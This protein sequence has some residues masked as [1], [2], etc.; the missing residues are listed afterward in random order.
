MMVVQALGAALFALMGLLAVMLTPIG[1][2]GAWMLIGVAGTVDATAMVFERGS[3]PFGA[4]SLAVAVGAAVA[5]ELLEFVAGAMG[6]RA[7]GA[8]RS[9]MV[10]SLV[11]GFVGVVVGTLAIPLPLVGSIVGA[12]LGVVLGA[13]VGEMAF[14]G[15]AL[16]DTVRP[17]AGAAIGRVVGSLAKLP[18]AF[19]AW[20]ALSYD[21]FT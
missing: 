16:G 1:V 8:S 10:G 4:E 12:L 2:P 9:G 13:V 14:H 20:A 21:A 11:G 7:G 3:L 6:A 5:G 15:R 19:I 18:C 17:A